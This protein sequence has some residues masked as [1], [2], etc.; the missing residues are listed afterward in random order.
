MNQKQMQPSLDSVLLD[1]HVDAAAGP[2][3]AILERYCTQYP[4]FAREL[5]D[6]AVQWLIGEAMAVAEPSSS[7]VEHSSSGLV[8]RAISRLYDRIRERD[9]ARSGTP[10]R[11]QQ[12]HGVFEGLGVERVREIRDELGLDTPLMSKL[13]NRLIDPETVPRAFLERFAKSLQRSVDEIVGYLKLP[14]TVHAQASFKAEGKPMTGAQR[15]SFDDAVRK[16]SLDEECR[17]AVLKG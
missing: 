17:R 13:R 10:V 5:T 12:S 2:N 4:Q 9:L 3:P 1:F 8:S 16:S 6:H 11:G 7:S 14:P 15:E